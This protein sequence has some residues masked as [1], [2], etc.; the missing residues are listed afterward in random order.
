MQKT[1]KNR[2]FDTSYRVNELHYHRNRHSNVTVYKPNRVVLLFIY[3]L[4]QLFPVTGDKFIFVD[5]W[6]RDR[7]DM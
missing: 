4:A 2:L 1:K 6:R 7:T 5:A 3:K